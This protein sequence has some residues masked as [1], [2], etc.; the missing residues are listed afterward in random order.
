MF[1]PIFAGQTLDVNTQ[2][3]A[4]AVK[5]L[6]VQLTRVSVISDSVD[7]IASEVKRFSSDFDFV[8]TSGG[9]GPTHDDLTFQ[10][11]Q[12]NYTQFYL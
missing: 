8:F 10:G 1:L 5:K 7:V 2:Y 11:E 3:L 12:S 9:G 6:G 4:G